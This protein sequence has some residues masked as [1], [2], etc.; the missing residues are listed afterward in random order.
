MPDSLVDTRFAMTW[1]IG[2]FG[3]IKGSI[4]DDHPG[5]PEPARITGR[6]I[7]DTVRFTKRY[8][9]LWLLDEKGNLSKFP[10][11]RSYVLYYE[12][13]FEGGETRIA[14]TWKVLPRVDR[15][16]VLFWIFER[17]QE[18]GLPYLRS[19]V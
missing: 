7:R 18:N 16:M 14:G 11:Q 9:S 1:V 6:F 19:A 10:G 13:R 12:G 8:S 17:Q 5:V 4:I 2:W 15:L 3:R